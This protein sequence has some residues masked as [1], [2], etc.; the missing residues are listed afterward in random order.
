MVK[1]VHRFRLILLI[2]FARIYIFDLPILKYNQ[3]YRALLWSVFSFIRRGVEPSKSEVRR[4]EA[5]R[6][7]SDAQ[8]FKQWRRF[9]LPYSPLIFISHCRLRSS[10]TFRLMPCTFVVTHQWKAILAAL[11]T[12]LISKFAFFLPATTYVKSNRVMS[13]LHRVFVF[14][15]YVTINYTHK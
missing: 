4:I 7:T 5:T 9:R 11:K 6:R 2:T 15:R 13:V 14:L 12:P 1:T 10:N 3:I 8:S